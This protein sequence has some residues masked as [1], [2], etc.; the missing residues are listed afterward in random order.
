MIKVGDIVSLKNTKTGLTT[1][2]SVGPTEY[3]LLRKKVGQ[4]VYG[5]PPH[6]EPLEILGQKRPQKR[7]RERRLRRRKRKGS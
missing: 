2:L 4:T 7:P 1:E 6:Y 5:P 3:Y